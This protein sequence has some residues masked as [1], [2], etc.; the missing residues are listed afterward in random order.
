MPV[1]KYDSI[2]REDVTM[3]GVDRVSACA[4]IGSDQGWSEN[5]LR[6]FR[7]APGGHTPQHQHDWEHVNHVIK[8]HGSLMIGDETFE[9]N[10]KDFAY[11]PPNTRH[12]FRNLGDTDFEFICVVPKRGTY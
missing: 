5:C 9:L 12:Q 2:K 8:G 7:I 4:V 6:V 10:E 1:Y 11:V 3:D